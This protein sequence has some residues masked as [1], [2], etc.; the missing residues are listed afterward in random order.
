[1]ENAI[2]LFKTKLEIYSDSN[3]RT[4]S[5]YKIFLASSANVQVL[6]HY[7]DAFC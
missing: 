3:N 2:Q 7:I 5:Y 4:R 6:I 1:M